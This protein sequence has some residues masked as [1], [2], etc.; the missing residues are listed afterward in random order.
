[1]GN[2]VLLARQ[3]ANAL[4]KHMGYKHCWRN[5]LM[6]LSVMPQGSM[7]QEGMMLM[8]LGTENGVDQWFP[9]DHE[10]PIDP[11]GDVVDSSMAMLNDDDKLAAYFRYV[12]LL[13]FDIDTLVKG[14]MLVYKN[15]NKSIWP[16]SL[17]AGEILLNNNFW[18]LVY[19][20]EAQKQQGMAKKLKAQIYFNYKQG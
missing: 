2:N 16:S 12:P 8:Y 11:N 13:T 7:Y 18:K 10:W 19:G 3:V 15:K 5:A 4:E 1:M 14:G 6:S 9:A 17:L 20:A